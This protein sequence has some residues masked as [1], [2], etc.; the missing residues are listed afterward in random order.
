MKI[1]ISTIVKGNYKWITWCDMPL[2][3]ILAIYTSVCILRRQLT[4]PKW[5]REK[6]SILRVAL[7]IVCLIVWFFIAIFAYLLMSVAPLQSSFYLVFAQNSTGVCFRTT[8][9]IRIVWFE[10]DVEEITRMRVLLNGKIRHG[11]SLIQWSKKH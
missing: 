3:G 9:M 4:S 7:L 1:S 5:F 10:K 2:D 8:Q 11:N 6:A